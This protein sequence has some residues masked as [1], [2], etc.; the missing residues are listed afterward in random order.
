[1]FGFFKKKAAPA[2]EPTPETAAPQGQVAPGTQ[3]AYDPNLIGTLM[4]DHQEIL[5]IF[6]DISQKFEAADYGGVSASLIDFRTALQGHLLTENVRLYIYLEHS[7]GSDPANYDL[8][9]GYKHEMDGIGKTVM[10]FLKKYD[11]IGVDA[12]LAASFGRDLQEVGG[13]LVKRVEAEERTLYPLYQ[14]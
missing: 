6:G 2:A 5:K 1:M 12:D 11:T 10:A 7:L 3:I 13:V 14:G 9:H 4:E 8:I